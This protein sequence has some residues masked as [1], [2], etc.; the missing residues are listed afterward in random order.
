MT[1][2]N[3]IFKPEISPIHKVD[4]SIAAQLKVSGAKT[5]GTVI[6]AGTILKGG[7]LANPKDNVAEVAV[8]ADAANVT[9]VLMH[10]VQLK[11][12]TGLETN[13]YSVGIMIEGVVYEDVMKLANG[14][15]NYDAT[16]QETLTA[17]GI[18]TYGAKTIG[19]K[20]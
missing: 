5:E 16:V 12:Q 20:R 1:E 19:I 9:G 3:S 8:V 11:A 7:F 18:K 2:L 13:N 6:P 15:A 4:F 14:D 17:L 10:D